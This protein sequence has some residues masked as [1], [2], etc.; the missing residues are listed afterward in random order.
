MVIF[1][2]MAIVLLLKP[3]GSVRKE[4]VRPTRPAPPSPYPR[5]RR[6]LGMPRAARLFAVRGVPAGRAVLPLSGLPDEGAVLRAVRLRLQP[7]ARLRRAALLRTRRL[8]RVRGLRGG[9]C[10]Q[11][12]GPQPR[13]RNPPAASSWPRCSGVGHRRPRDPAAGDLFRDGDAR[14][15]RRWSSSSASRRPSP[16]ARTA[17]RR[18]RAAGCSA[19]S[20]SPAPAFYFFVLADRVIVGS[21]LIYRIIHS[22]FG[23]VLRRSARTSRARSRSA[24][25]QPLQA[26]GVRDVR[27]AGRLPGRPRRWCSSSASLTDVALD[28]VR[29]GGADGAAG[30]MGTIFGPIVGAGIVVDAAEVI[31]RLRGAG[32]RH[33]G[34]RLRLGVP[35]VP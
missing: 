7:A 1:V 27:G 9:A 29:R 15:S 3:A 30:R 34:R 4:R 17:S 26:G 12:L 31:G 22:P 8:L 16:A 23:H 19:S 2:I 6:S 28:D 25:S 24:I 32:H 14:S 5:R 33:R 13:A 18:C 11:G 20:T 35:S 21:S 10:R